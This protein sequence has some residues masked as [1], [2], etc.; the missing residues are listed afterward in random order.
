[1][2]SCP[3]LFLSSCLC[4]SS[5]RHSDTFVPSNVS[6][7]ELPNVLGGALLQGEGEEEH[8]GIPG[9]ST[10]GGHQT[11]EGPDEDVAPHVDDAADDN[12]NACFI[13][14][15][16]LAVQIE[17]DGNEGSSVLGGGRGGSV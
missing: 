17:Q 1:M 13:S 9:S 12:E 14:L 15:N 2:D 16:P 11:G 7:T 10:Q 3:L 6:R 4:S 8:A 5:P